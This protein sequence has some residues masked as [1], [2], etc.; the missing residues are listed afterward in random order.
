M[1]LP[2]VLVLIVLTA[3]SGEQVEAKQA[4]GGATGCP[5]VGGMIE[6]PYVAGESTARSIAQA[7]V[8]QMQWH[9]LQ[10]EYDLN[11]RDDGDAWIAFQSP[12]ERQDVRGG[13]GLTMRIS[14]CDG[15]ISSMH[16]QR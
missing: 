14:K 15:A 3:C 16:W 12:K 4:V 1:R 10:A 8:E 7:V 11:I 13:G 2:A 5:H 9:D 6:G